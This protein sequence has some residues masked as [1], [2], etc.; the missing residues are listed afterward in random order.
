MI[1]NDKNYEV[2]NNLE[3]ESSHFEIAA[4]AK[5]FDILSSKL[6]EDPQRAIIRE[7]CCN[8]MDA[9]TV[10]NVDSPIRVY[11]P[12]TDESTLIIE[13]EGIG[14]THE[15]VMTVYKSY[16]KSTKSS[17][18]QVIGALGLGG[19]TPLAYTQQ[20]VLTTTRDGERNEYVIHKDEDGI[21]NVTRVA[22]SASNNSGTIVEM[23]VKENDIDKFHVAAIQTFLFF[24]RMPHIVRG[25]ENFYYVMT[26]RFNTAI[27][28]GSD[29]LS[30]WKEAR[31]IISKDYLNNDEDR[32]A[33]L[34]NNILDKYSSR[35]MGVVMGQ[36]YYSVNIT[37]VFNED[38]WDRNAERAAYF[39]LHNRGPYSQRKVFHVGMGDVSFQPSREVLNYNTSTIKKLRERFYSNFNEFHDEMMDIAPTGKKFLR[40]FDEIKHSSFLS[41]IAEWSVYGNE[42]IQELKDVYEDTIEEMLSLVSAGSL[43]EVTLNRKRWDMQNILCNPGASFANVSHIFD[44]V[45]KKIS[46]Y[47]IVILDD[48]K[49]DD[50]CAQATIENK[51]KNRTNFISPGVV[52]NRLNELTI[53]TEKVLLI[54]PNIEK[55]MR[56]I[57]PHVL[58][59]NISALAP[60]KA[61]RA[62]TKAEAIAKISVWDFKAGKEISGTEAIKKAKSEIVTY[63]I[64]EGTPGIRG[65]WYT[66][67]WDAISN[68]AKLNGPK[69]DFLIENSRGKY[70]SSSARYSSI[71]HS[72]NMLK[73][74]IADMPTHYLVSWEFYK[75][76]VCGPGKWMHI[77]HYFINELKKSHSIIE[78]NFSSITKM[79]QSVLS[80]SM[81]EVNRFQ[82]AALKY[83]GF[84]NTT[85]G[86]EVARR[87]VEIEKISNSLSE[88]EVRL[89]LLAAVD[90]LRK[91]SYKNDAHFQKTM[92]CYDQWHSTVASQI[93]SEGIDYK[94]EILTKYPMIKYVLNAKLLSNNEIDDVVDYIAL[95]EGL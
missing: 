81:P 66:P 49:I 29:Y 10:A 20:F 45:H 37:Q 15:D 87:I 6:Y 76:V 35:G 5:M 23:I 84:A 68:A 54:S 32:A 1:L 65:V 51:A 27:P 24:D 47:T 82:T 80:S 41:D 40:K 93:N 73:L 59:V 95:V 74:R 57:F 39:P 12:T 36:I 75:K 11:L 63:E 31:A 18:N 53:I 46:N 13:D 25:E 85:F 17:N 60:K 42:N 69:K 88:R 89:G 22:T 52:R 86:K 30:L 3:T 83:S 67:M 61:S 50:K 58:V 16:G 4:N 2:T 33:Q 34:V 44:G 71:R 70:S 48:A 90:T 77:D 9:N 7:L 43:Y 38:E 8:A 21:P 91:I 56:A 64:F 19:K 94:P 92:E 14:M 28:R 79:S 72:M 78:S 55:N 26:S 62:A